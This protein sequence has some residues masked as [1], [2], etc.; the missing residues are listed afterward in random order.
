MAVFS[1]LPRKAKRIT[2]VVA[3]IAPSRPVLPAGRFLV[4]FFVG[5]PVGALGASPRN[6]RGADFFGKQKKARK[7]AALKKDEKT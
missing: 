7:Q 1:G 5:S 6:R 4:A 2:A 3:A